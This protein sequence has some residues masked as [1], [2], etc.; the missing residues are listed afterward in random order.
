MSGCM[1]SEVD[2]YKKYSL[3]LLLLLHY[4]FLQYNTSDDHADVIIYIYI[5]ILGSILTRTKN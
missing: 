1:C 5:L 3:F 2:Y 4:F